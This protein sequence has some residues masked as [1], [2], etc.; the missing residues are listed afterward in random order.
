MQIICSWNFLHYGPNYVVLGVIFI[1]ETEGIEWR[2]FHKDL[3]RNS[4]LE[5][6]QFLL[7]IPVSPGVEAFDPKATTL[8]VTSIMERYSM[9]SRVSRVSRVVYPGSAHP[10]NFFLPGYLTGTRVPDLLGINSSI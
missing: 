9:R 4:E 6:S 3:M 2:C 5:I 10:G 1:G 8:S 7:G